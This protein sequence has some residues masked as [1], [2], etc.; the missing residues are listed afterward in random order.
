MNDKKSRGAFCEV[1]LNNILKSIFGEREEYYK[2]Q[3]KLS[4]G[5][6]VDALLKVPK[7]VGNIAIDSK[8]PLESY[9]RMVDPNLEAG[10]ERVVIRQFKNDLRKHIDDISD[11]Y[12]IEPETT[13]SAIMFLPAEALFAQINAYHQDIIEYAAKKKVWLTSPTTL[14]A[15]LTSIQVIVQNIEQSKYAKVIHDH[16]QKLNIEFQ[17]YNIRWENLARKMESVNKETYDIHTTTKKISS[18]FQK[19]SNVQFDE[20]EVDLI[21]E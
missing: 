4:N 17:R 10:L 3:H 21:D 11:K 15:T 7:P 14:M 8:F 9:R 12:I 1:Q 16:L 5:M 2:I 6:L 20:K 19:I 18:E 13:N